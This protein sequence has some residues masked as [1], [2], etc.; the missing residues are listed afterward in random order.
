[1]IISCA[2][3]DELTKCHGIVDCVMKLL[4]FVSKINLGSE[5]RTSS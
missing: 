4:D 1:M 2:Y 5:G 3:V